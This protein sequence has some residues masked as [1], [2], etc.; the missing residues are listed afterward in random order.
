MSSIHRV[1]ARVLV[2]SSVGLYIRFLISKSKNDKFN[3]FKETCVILGK[4]TAKIETIFQLVYKT[5]LDLYRWSERD[6]LYR[7]LHQHLPQL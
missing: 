5:W 7:L 2:K 6:I 4:K 3:E 1:V